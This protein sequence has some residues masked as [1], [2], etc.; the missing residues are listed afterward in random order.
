MIIVVA[1]GVA[2]DAV[3]DRQVA[4]TLGTAEGGAETD[5]VDSGATV[6]MVRVADFSIPVQVSGEVLD[7]FREINEA[8][9]LVLARLDADAVEML[10]VDHGNVERIVLAILERA[11]H[12]AIGRIEVEITQMPRP[13]DERA[14]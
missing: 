9:H 11:V 3:P 12:L 1:P 10:H 5:A 8:K 4:R 6:P 14:D 7:D 13:T 2:V